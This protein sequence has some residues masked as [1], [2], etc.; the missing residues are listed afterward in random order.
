[1]AY[2]RVL[3]DAEGN[4]RAIVEAVDATPAELETTEVNSSIYAFRGEVLWPALD[5]LESHNAQGELYLTDSVRYIVS[6]GGGGA[7][8]EAPAP[9]EALGVNT[10]VELAAAAAVLRDRINEEHML[11][12]V[13][14][15]DPETTWIEVDV[16]L[17]KD[18][19]IQPFTF[20]ARDTRIDSGAQIG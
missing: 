2:G 16:T 6:N 5:S 3:R 19:T 9:V 12:G 8:Y 15:V 17:S 14:I 11:A 13:T 1:G 10:R 20:I 7:V 18:V 4:L